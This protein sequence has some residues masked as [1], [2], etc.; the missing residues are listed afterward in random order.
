MS[1]TPLLTT[2]YEALT[3]RYE[4]LETIGHGSFGDV[5]KA[6]RLDD[7]V[8]VAL[9]IPRDQELG[10]EALRREPDLMRAFDHPN[11]VRVYQC[12][13]IGP[14]FVIEMEYIDGHN[15]GEML[16]GI[17]H[18]QPLSYRRILAWTQQILEGLQA[19]H[20]AHVVHADIKPQN[21]LIGADG[22]AKL[23]DFGTSRRIEDVLVWTQRQ[24]TEAYWAPEVAFDSQRSFVSDIYSVGVMLYE[25]VTG[26]LPYRSPFELASGRA[27]PRPREINAN[28][29]PRL[30]AIILRA[31]ARDPRDRY[32]SC[33][34][35]LSDIAALC[36]EMDAGAVSVPPDR[37]QPARVTFRPDSSSPLYYLEQ[38]RN[39]LKAD[40][41]QGALQAAETAVQRSNGHPSYLRLLGAI[42]VRMGYP[43]K[44]LE[45]YEKVL[46]AYQ[47]DFPATSTQLRELLERL[48]DLYIQTQRYRQ[49]VQTYEQ[50]LTVAT[51]LTYAKFRLAVALGLDADYR[52]AIRLLEEV[53][54]ERP[55]AVVV[56]AKLGWAHELIGDERQAISYY[57]Q[58]LVFDPTDLFSL[59]ALGRY[60]WIKGHRSR[61]RSYFDRVRQHDSR[62]EYAVRLQEILGPDSS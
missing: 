58:A 1:R 7:G 37:T 8:T 22:N 44:A 48:G 33:T 42:Y 36:A 56:Y 27:V 43:H 57:N 32:P 59:Y 20:N 15:L 28:V 23:V 9:K 35:M 46:A 24:G 12:R 14:W 30:E 55:D 39:R 47:R 13:T 45:T 34:A 4:L 3:A 60:Y 51:N 25:M 5:W 38:A 26:S 50:M 52:R 6:H 49:A 18:K 41:L 40:D 17:T 31:M 53:R 54:Q 21:V 16:D 11:I 61:A 29:P 10:E 2:P 62:G 19:I